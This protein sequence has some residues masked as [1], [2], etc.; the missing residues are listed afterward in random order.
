MSNKNVRFIFALMFVLKMRLLMTGIMNKHN[1]LCVSYKDDYT[2]TCHAS[3][4]TEFQSF[5]Q[6]RFDCMRC[7][8]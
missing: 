1:L 3:V 7:A 6:H 4:S 5:R 2:V 8:V